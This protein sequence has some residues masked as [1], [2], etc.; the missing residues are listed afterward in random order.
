MKL[1]IQPKQ[2]R[3]LRFQE[4]TCSQCVWYAAVWTICMTLLHFSPTYSV[5]ANFETKPAIPLQQQ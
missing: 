1:V 4:F 3:L 2:Q 5:P